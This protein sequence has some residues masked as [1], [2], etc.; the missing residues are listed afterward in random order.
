[1]AGEPQ[2][3]D[4]P[5]DRV[6]LSAVAL[7]DLAPEL[8]AALAQLAPAPAGGGATARAVARL[9][10][11]PGVSIADVLATKCPEGEEL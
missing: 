5:P 3:A 1:M 6:S 11:G 9:L 7:R 4:V 8:A 2:V 10:A